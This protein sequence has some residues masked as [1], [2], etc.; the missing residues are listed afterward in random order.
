[1]PSCEIS[2]KCVLSN[3]PAPVMLEGPT[4][5]KPVLGL[6]S[7]TVDRKLCLLASSFFFRL[8]TSE[9]DPRREFYVSSMFG[10]CEK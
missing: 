9:A 6:L 3:V 1:M 4:I 10:V 8:L 2:V 7:T 5:T